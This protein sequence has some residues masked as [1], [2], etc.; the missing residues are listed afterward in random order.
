VTDDALQRTET[1]FLGPGR[2]EGRYRTIEQV[3]LV[4]QR[5]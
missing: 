3:A 1:R 5:A 4:L 2:R